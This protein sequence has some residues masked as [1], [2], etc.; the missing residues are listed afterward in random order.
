MTL[1]LSNLIPKIYA[2]PLHFAVFYHTFESLYKIL[3]YVHFSSVA[4]SCLTLC[5]PMNCSMPSLPVHHQL[6][7]PTQIHVH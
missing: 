1:I 6:P 4:Q 3:W 5:G 2:F 7:G